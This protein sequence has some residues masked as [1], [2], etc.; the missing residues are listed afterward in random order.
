MA[1]SAESPRILN[2]AGI[3]GR[4][5][6]SGQAH[7]LRASQNREVLERGSLPNKNFLIHFIEN[8]SIFQ[9]NFIILAV[10]DDPIRQQVHLRNRICSY[11]LNWIHQRLCQKLQSRIRNRFVEYWRWDESNFMACQCENNETEEN[12]LRYFAFDCPSRMHDPATFVNGKRKSLSSLVIPI[13]KHIPPGVPFRCTGIVEK[14]FSHQSID[15]TTTHRRRSAFF[16]I[17]ASVQT[18]H[19]CPPHDVRYLIWRFVCHI[20]N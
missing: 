4:H 15:R 13:F 8:P 11:L 18:L 19:P 3:Q 10:L 7:W 9:V 20:S 2:W 16:R 14:M 6:D 12:V 1:S 17:L 5:I